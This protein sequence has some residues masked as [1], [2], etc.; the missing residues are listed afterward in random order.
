MKLYIQLTEHSIHSKNNQVLSSI[1][2]LSTIIKIDEKKTPEEEY[3]SLFTLK[4]IVE[5][6]IDNNYML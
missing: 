3:T 4:K 2:F 6:N 1:I 5:N